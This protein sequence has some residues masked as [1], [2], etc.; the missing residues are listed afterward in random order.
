MLNRVQLPSV[1]LGVA[2]LVAL[3]ADARVALRGNDSKAS[4][5]SLE[6]AL[7]LIKEHKKPGNLVVH[8][9]LLSPSE[10]SFLGSVSASPA[11]PSARLRASRRILLL[12]VASAPMHGFSSP[13]SRFLI[14]GPRPLV[15]KIFEPTNEASGS[16]FDLYTDIERAKM[17]IE[18]PAGKVVSECTRTRAQGGRGCPGEAD[19]LH[20]DRRELVIDGK[21][22]TC[23]WAHPTTGGVIVFELPAMD[24][25]APGASLWLKVSAGLTDDSVKST[26]DGAHVDTVIKQK[27]KILGRIRTPNRVGIYDRSVAIEGGEKTTLR[28]ISPKD[29]RRHHYINASIEERR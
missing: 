22:Q 21:K 3:L 19:W 1:I 20:L 28:I 5:E 17:R 8:S 15:L 27:N 10:L 14:D 2:L 13:E 4:A 25:P 18:R 6:S 29:G 16:L 11:L 24:I 23:V 7:K 12:D 9:P 26:P